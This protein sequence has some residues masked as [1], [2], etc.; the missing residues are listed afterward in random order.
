MKAISKN[1]WILAAIVLLAGFLFLHLDLID[2]SAA[3]FIAFPLMIGFSIGTHDKPTRRL[4]FLSLTLILFFGFLLAVGLEGLMCVLM[5]MP[6]VGVSML[7]GYAARRHF[8]PPDPP[9][10]STRDHLVVSLLPLLFVVCADKVEALLVAPPNLIEIETTVDLPFPATQVFD[11]V[12]AMDKLDAPK[13]WGI[14]LGLPAPYRCILP[15]DTVGARRICLFENG[16]IVAEI[17]KFERGEILEMDVVDYTLTGREWFQ[18]NDATY[19]FKKTAT[20]T[21]ITR[22]S[23]YR[24]VLR[25]R[26][27]WEPLEKWGIAQEH[28]FVLASLRKNLDESQPAE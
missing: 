13:P 3:F 28:D 8:Y 26:W 14:W 12:K 7:L 5:A 10:K 22:T 20:G 18:F 9:T 15:A 24:S 2:Y 19:S 17:T 27:Y 6:V 11:H 21:A 1:S 23:S 16:R 25:P 4:L